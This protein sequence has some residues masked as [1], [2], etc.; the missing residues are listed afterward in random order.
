MIA[1]VIIDIQNKQINKTFDY[2]VPS[3]LEDI[4][5]IG[6]RVKVPFG[7]TLR[8]AYVINIKNE[9]KVER[10]KEIIDIVDVIPIL[11]KEFIEIAK[12]ISTNYFTYYATILDAMIPKSLKIKYKKVAK[13]LTDNLCL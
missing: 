8:V 4:I 9:T 2:I 10:L 11:N 3:Y 13:L 7:N 12:Y 5:D 1:E 6:L